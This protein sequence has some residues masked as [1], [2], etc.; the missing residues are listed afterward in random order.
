ML[1]NIKCRMFLLNHVNAYSLNIALHVICSQHLRGT[2]HKCTHACFTFHTH[3]DVQ[4]MLKMM[5]STLVKS[6]SSWSSY[7]ST[8]YGVPPFH[9]RA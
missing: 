9:A 1:K 6:S 5:W 8:A 3:Y 4:K 2:K 7:L